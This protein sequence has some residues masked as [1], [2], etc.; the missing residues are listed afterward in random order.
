MMKALC[1]PSPS[2]SVCTLVRNRRTN[3]E[4]LMRGLRASTQAPAELV[5]VHMNE[6]IYP[7]ETLPAV[8]F[9]VRQVQL[10]EESAA[11]PLARARN[12]AVRHARHDHLILLDV[13]C[14]PDPEMIATLLRDVQVVGGLVMGTIRYLG[15][16]VNAPGWTFE[17]L[18][19]G[20]EL[21]VRRPV[22][23]AGEPL[24][25][26]NYALFWSLCFICTRSVWEQLGGFDEQFPGYGGEDT[27]FAFTA[28][29][30][31]VPFHLSN[32]LCYHQYHPISRPP[33][34][35]FDNIVTNSRVF[36]RKWGRWC[37]E[38]W[39]AQFAER[40]LIEWSEAEKD[41]H[42]L[43]RPTAEEVCAATVE[44]AY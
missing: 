3:L 36:H 34:H 44:L 43:R 38:G 22:V 16:D 11:L 28:E 41:I 20:S 30:M 18:R 23:A 40:G 13:D 27:D 6:D 19:A 31:G 21:H 17:D 32:A 15:P 2:V 26:P 37:M 42:V 14:I 12:L 39:L 5:I 8:D 9:P 33:L 7:L 35:N 24:A 29:K 1:M 10:I 25:A 4:N